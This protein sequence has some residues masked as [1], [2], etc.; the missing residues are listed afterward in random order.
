MVTGWQKVADKWYFFNP[1]SNGTKGKMLT[2]WQW[3]DGYCYYF[4]EMKD[5]SHVEGEMWSGEVT[6]DGYIVDGS[7]RWTDAQGIVQ[8]LEGKGILTF[9][10]S[11]AQSRFSS[12]G[13]VSY[14]HLGSACG[15]PAIHRASA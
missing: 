7:G 9:K 2:G 5:A 15:W 10:Q 6:P 13:S 3:I 1:I 4:T 8:F 12:G 11:H 14:T